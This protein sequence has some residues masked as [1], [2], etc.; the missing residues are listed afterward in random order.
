MFAAFGRGTIVDVVRQIESFDH[1]LEPAT[2]P[3]GNDLGDA[4]LG[5]RCEIMQQ[6][7][8]RSV[9]GVVP[10]ATPPF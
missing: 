7:F 3:Q 10:A 6:F 2:V 4:R 8:F 1:Q 5:E 9:T